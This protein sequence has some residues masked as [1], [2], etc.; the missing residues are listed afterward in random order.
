M[1]FLFGRRGRAEREAAPLAVDRGLGVGAALAT[2]AR[3]AVP[4]E[5]PPEEEAE[6]SM[7]RWRRP[8]LMAARKEAPGTS[9]RADAAHRLRFA[10]TTRHPAETA[11]HTIRYRMVQLT[12]RP[13]EIYGIELDRLDEGD[14]VEVLE[15]VGGYVRVRT[16]LGQEGWVHR[17]TV[18]ERLGGPVDQQPSGSDPAPQASQEPIDLDAVFRDEPEDAYPD[19]AEMSPA[20]RLL[21]EHL[22]R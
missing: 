18:G 19:R 8:S 21:E 16:P 10:T 9:L 5:T 3:L 4:V 6:A 14:E 15:R 2:P 1:G 13:D 17:T 20:A 12:D 7:P 11:I 22:R